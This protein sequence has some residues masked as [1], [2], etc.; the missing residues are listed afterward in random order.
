MKAE[1]RK[2]LQT[3]SLADFLGRTVRTARTRE[4]IPWFWVFVAGIVVA[5]L[6]L[7]WWIFANR[8]RTRAEN[9]AR[10]EYNDRTSL[11]QLANDFPETNPGQAARFTIAF[12]RLWRLVSYELAVADQKEV[13]DLLQGGLQP[14][15]SKLAEECKEDPERLAEAKYHME[16]IAELLAGVDPSMRKSHLESAKRYLEELTGDDLKSTGYGKLAQKRLE[17]FNSPVEFRKIDTFYAEFPVRSK[18]SKFGD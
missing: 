3:N 13:R 5:G 18:F 14:F 17:Q 15:Y 6:L 4:G 7:T 9:W 8:A 12:D 16:V 2:E 1:H 11:Q 10:V